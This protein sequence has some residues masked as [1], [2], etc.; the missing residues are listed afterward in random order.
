MRQ[1]HNTPSPLHSLA[2]HYDRLDGVG[3]AHVL[4]ALILSLSA[5]I[6][7]ANRIKCSERHSFSHSVGVLVLGVKGFIQA[8]AAWGP[9]HCQTARSSGRDVKRTSRVIPVYVIFSAYN[10]VCYRGVYQI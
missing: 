1:C 2:V 9:L 3:E 7:S 8:N 10:C 6:L 5:V 4:Q